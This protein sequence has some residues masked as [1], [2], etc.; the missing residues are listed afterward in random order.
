VT[1]PVARHP[2]SR[3]LVGCCGIAGQ[4]G[5]N[6]VCGGCGVEVATRESDCWTDNPV[7]LIAT[8]VTD[9]PMAS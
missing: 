4:D 9:E 1:F 5:P 6:L 3:R 8:A 7:A 2:D